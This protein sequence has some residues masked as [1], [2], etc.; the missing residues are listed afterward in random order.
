L[1]GPHLI[2]LSIGLLFLATKSVLTRSVDRWLAGGLAACALI[3]AL[4][5]QVASTAAWERIATVLTS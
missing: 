3:N 2:P 1:F 5:M 4:G